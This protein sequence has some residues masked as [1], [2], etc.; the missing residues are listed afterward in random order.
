MHPKV[1]AQLN[2]ML[3]KNSTEKHKRW[4][5]GE[6]EGRGDIEKNKNSDRRMWMFNIPPFMEKY[7]RRNITSTDQ[8]TNR[9]ADIRD[10]LPSMCNREVTLPINSFC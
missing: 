10:I 1:Q 4:G 9:Q 8:P 2:G 5:R 6:T 3:P 7:D